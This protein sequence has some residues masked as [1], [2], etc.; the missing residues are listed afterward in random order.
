MVFL[1]TAA[2]MQLCGMREF[3]LTLVVRM[4]YMYRF[5]HLAADHPDAIADRAKRDTIGWQPR[6][7]RQ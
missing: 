4:L 2:V 3:V 7:P 1:R 6:N 5:R